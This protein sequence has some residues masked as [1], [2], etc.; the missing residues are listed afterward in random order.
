MISLEQVLGSHTL[1][2]KH[3]RVVRRGVNNLNLLQSAIDGQYWYDNYFDCILHVAFSVN[4][5]YVFYDGNKR[6]CYMLIKSSGYCF[7]EDMLVDTILA[8]ADGRIRDKEQFF[9]SI[10]RC[11]L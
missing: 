2:E 8:L 6:T 4:A 9:R 1:L 5:F 7:N 3:K 11:I 10:K